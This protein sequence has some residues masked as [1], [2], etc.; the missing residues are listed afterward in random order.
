MENNSSLKKTPLYETHVE[1]GAKFTEFGGWLMPVQYSGLIDEH[2]TVRS[3][4]G[5]FD[6]SHMGEI[7]VKGKGAVS[8]LQYAATNDVTRL[9]K[10]QAQYSLLLN[11]NGGVVDDIIIYR[12]GDEEFF[13]C[14][15]ASN[16]EKDFAHLSN[17]N[18]FG[19][20]I[21][22][23][24]GLYA[25]IAVQGPDAAR[26]LGAVLQVREDNLALA[27]FPYFTYREIVLPNEFGVKA[28]SLVARTGYTG[29][30]G[31][32]VFLPPQSVKSF[33]DALAEAGLEFGAKPVGLGARDTLRLEV[34]YPLH[35]HELRD[36]ICA[37]S[38][39]VSWA[40]KLQ[41][42]DF[43][44][45]E[46]LLCE[47]DKGLAVQL[48]ALEVISPGIVRADA[49]VFSG[50]REIG[51]I[52]S[53]TKTPTTNKAVALAYLS[54]PE[55]KLGNTVEVEVRGKRVKARIVEAPFVKP[56]NKR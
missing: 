50:D 16:A 40:I 42:G 10:K 24:S 26:L 34:C 36:D 35:G 25:Q 29:E 18:R 56:F 21:E 32:E 14:V 22:N 53:G 15:N 1:N 46:A 27:A 5:L 51:W 17:L 20:K 52:T 30:D 49:L 13:I 39:N 45:R 28:K 2:L 33:W 12:T 9:A 8:L 38:A 7:T 31:F 23:V 43:F 44:G 37:L 3:R 47:R 4:A 19:A 41:K 48:A 11:E 55:A 54:P 6:V